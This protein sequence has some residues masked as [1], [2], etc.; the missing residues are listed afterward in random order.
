MQLATY[1]FNSCFDEKNRIVELEN[2]RNLPVFMKVL[3]PKEI[4][5][6]K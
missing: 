2:T 6:I 3:K 4:R 5:R 1:K